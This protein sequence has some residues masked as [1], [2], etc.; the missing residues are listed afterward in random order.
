MIS[1]N[2]LE[3][4][5]VDLSGVTT[6]KRLPH[7]HPGELLNEEFLGPL[8]ISQYRLAKA[9]HV[10]PRRINEIVQGKRGITADTAVR[11]GTFFGMTATFWMN[12]QAAYDLELARAD[13]DVGSI[14]RLQAA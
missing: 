8:A 3:F 5:T 12:L 14:E 11:L 7:I 6:G 9:I 10:A 4:G 1:R 2:D 13:I